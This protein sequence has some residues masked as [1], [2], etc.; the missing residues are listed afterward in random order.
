MRRRKDRNRE[1][2]AKGKAR[3]QAMAAATAKDGGREAARE[4]QG[5]KA[6]QEP[7]RAGLGL[8]REPESEERPALAPAPE[9][10]QGP[11][12][13]RGP[14]RGWVEEP[15]RVPARKSG[16]QALEEAESSEGAAGPVRKHLGEPG[17]A[18]PSVEASATA[19]ERAEGDSE[20]GVPGW[21]R[22]WGRAQV[23]E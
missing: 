4:E 16:G 12:Q 11:G 14:A 5:P 2:K 18:E 3:D 23:E 1:R 15:E 20:S 22:E 10:E 13:A 21:V 19:A 7:E 9:P 8:G 17:A 6:E